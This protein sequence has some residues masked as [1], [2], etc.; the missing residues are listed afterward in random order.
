M[1]TKIITVTQAT[2]SLMQKWSESTGARLADGGTV[3]NDDGT[4]SFP[5]SLDVYDALVA[6]GLLA[7]GADEVICRAIQGGPGSGFAS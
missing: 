6:R 7:L 2:H 1:N 5:V 3:L 4:L